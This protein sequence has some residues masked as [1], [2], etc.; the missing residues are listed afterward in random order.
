MVGVDLDVD[1]RLQFHQD[2]RLGSSRDNRSANSAELPCD[3][4]DN[5][6]TI[7]GR[8]PYAAC[9]RL[10]F[11]HRHIPWFGG[12]SYRSCSKY[13]LVETSGQSEGSQIGS[14]KKSSI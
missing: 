4:F 7:V 5:R 9:R 14:T 11:R 13:E 6:P 3:D 1:P 12:E 2:F 10:N 8:L